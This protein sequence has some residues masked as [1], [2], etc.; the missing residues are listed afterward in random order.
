MAVILAQYKA[1]LADEIAKGHA[2][3][4]KVAPRKPYREEDAS[5]EGGPG[6]DI[7]THPWLMN[8]PV[9]AASDL[10]S[11]A[12]ENSNATDEAL[13]RIEELNPELKQQPRLQAELNYRHSHRYTP[14]PTPY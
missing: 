2:Q 7:E 10:T 4:G 3:F 8:I 12:S 13:D 1:Q 5:G 11:I 9:G 14:K 6:I